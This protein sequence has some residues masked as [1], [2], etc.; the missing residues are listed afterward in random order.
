MTVVLLIVYFSVLAVLALQALTRLGY[1]WSGP[2]SETCAPEPSEWPAV[3]VQLPM[4][5]EALVAGRVIEAVSRLRYPPDRLRVQVLDD[6]TDGSTA[7]VDAVCTRMAAQGT[8]IEVV[9]REERRGFKAGALA[10]GLEQSDEPLVAIFDADFVPP[11]DFLER[12]VPV[13]AADHGL[14]LVQARWSHLNREQSLLTR[15]QAVFLDGHFAGEHAARDRR[16][17]PFNFNGTAGIWRRKAIEAAGGW[18]G[19][20]ITEDLDLSYRAQMAGWRF[21]YLHAVTAPAELPDS[22]AAYRAQQAR[23][24]RGSMQTARK[25]S[26]ALLSAPWPLEKRWVGLH[27]LWSNLV[28]LVM[29][30]LAVLLPPVLVLREE[31]GWRV[32]GGRALLG[33]L[34]VIMLAGGTVALGLFWVVSAR[35]CARKPTVDLLAA[36][37]LGVG[38]SFA[39]ARAALAGLRSSESIFVRTPKRGENSGGPTY[40]AKLAVGPIGFELAAAVLHGATLGY[41]LYWQVWGAAPFLALYAL[42][43]GWAGLGTLLEGWREGRAERSALPKLVEAE[44]LGSALGN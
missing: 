42:G 28:Y 21:A 36:F 5:N 16:A 24:V 32:P 9:R 35:R 18:S 14:G 13:L 11:P 10:V 19:D 4:Y 17:H 26:S 8:R 3:L 20:T 27:H 12:S 6:S 2:P 43:F 30:V 44:D 40:R 29:A 31:L 25:L 33:G 23:W 15:A 7:V 22:W 39:N 1:L 38:M 41:A 37:V 34:D